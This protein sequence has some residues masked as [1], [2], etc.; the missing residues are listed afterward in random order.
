MLE[1]IT[2]STHDTTNFELF[3]LSADK[4]GIDATRIG[5]GKKYTGHHL[6]SL[7]LME[8]LKEQPYHKLMLYTDSMDAFFLGGIDEI[9]HKYA[10][11]NAPLVLSAEQNL[12]IR[13]TSTFDKYRRYRRLKSNRSKPYRFLNAGGWIGEAGEMLRILENIG[14]FGNIDDQEAM[15]LYYSDHPSELTIDS[16]HEIF[17]C[18]AGRTG[19]EK[20]DYRVENDRVINVITGSKPA[21]M[22]FA[23]NNFTGG[24]KILS[25]LSMFGEL[26]YPA[27]PPNRWNHFKNRLT[28]IF[29]TDNYFFHLVAPVIVLLV[30]LTVI[31][32]VF[33]V[34]F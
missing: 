14:A 18:T 22:H 2:I 25:Q 32:L 15:N 24:N 10:Q 6:K 27:K 19:L 7:W 3:K 5:Y 30:C 28:S 33:F 26:R 1:V 29:K 21:I 34:Y 8:F 12:N 4:L 9:L 23:A 11:F 16:N 20:L 31:A 17:S 13:P